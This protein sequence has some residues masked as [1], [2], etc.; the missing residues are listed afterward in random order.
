MKIKSIINIATVSAIVAS[1][2][3]TG[4][5]SSSKASVQLS[6]VVN[7]SK[8]QMKKAYTT[9]STPIQKTGKLPNKATVIAEYNK[10]KKQYITSKKT[11]QK[12]SKS[13]KKK[14]LTELNSTYKMYITSRVEPYLNAATLLE[15][16]TKVESEFNEAL[17]NEDIDSLEIAHQKLGKYITSK[18][19]NTYNK[20]FDAKAKKIFLKE[21]MEQKTE[22]NTYKFDVSVSN[23]LEQVTSFLEDGELAK[24]NA[25]LKSIKPLLSHTSVLF[26]EELTKEYT[27]LLEVYNDAITPPTADLDYIDAINGKLTLEFDIAV[28]S[29]TTNDVKI[30]VII[31]GGTEQI[32]TPKNIT[33]SDDKT[34]AF[35]T[36]DELNATSTVQKIEYS[37]EFNGEK[38]SADAFE[39]PAVQ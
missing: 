20:V 5:P 15:T 24:S 33:L 22:F 26:K 21:Y 16:S 37:V 36:I 31:N 13:A 34:S 28:K 25:V 3:L 4:N 11:V 1:A 18:Q 2:F 6:K 23:K 27:D 12:Y 10:A 19:F 35:I 9:Y 8:A 7:E 32:I 17:L 30:S 39:I 29:L 14:Y 38:L